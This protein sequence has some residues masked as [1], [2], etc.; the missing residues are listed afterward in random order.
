M[1]M[2]QFHRSKP[3]RKMALGIL[4]TVL[5]FCGFFSNCWHAAEQEWFLHFQHDDE[6]LVIGRMV[7]ARGDGI[8][9]AGGMLGAGI[10]HNIH[11]EWISPEEADHQYT[12][13]LTGL[14]FADYSPYMSQIGGQAMF[15]SLL[16][17]M[18]PLLPRTKINIY[19]IFTSL[20]SAVALTLVVLWFY[21][22]FG[23]SVM[24]FVL[25]SMVFSQWL[26]V[27]GRNLWWSLWVFYLP[28][29]AVMRFYRSHS[30]AEDPRFI[31]L[32]VLTF[33]SV[34]VKC[35]F[36]GYEYMTTTLLMMV[37]PFVYYGIL[38][39]L[40]GRQFLRGAFAAALGSC[41]AIGVT[42]TILCFQIDSIR[43]N[44]QGVTHITNSLMKRTYGNEHAFPAVYAASL[45]SNVID[46]V[47]AYVEGVFFDANNYLSPH[48]HFISRYLFI[49]RY[50]FLI[51]LFLAASLLI[52]FRRAGPAV[53]KQR[54][55]ALLCATWF[56]LL[57]PLSWFVIFKAHSFIHTHMN[58]IVWQM[59]FVFFGFA[60]C[61]MAAK[62]LLSGLLSCPGRGSDGN[63]P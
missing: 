14:T 41:L 59:P 61:G 39:R 17:R 23:L 44:A 27:F 5:L 18:L 6:S 50:Y 30:P 15:F 4:S 1:Q 45:K 21:D 7:K 3:A 33:V 29:I 35:L 46:V 26:T 9:S 54:N 58:F 56:S 40:N 53:V 2:K 28:M 63:G 60:V 10:R 22:E 48:S 16:D 38:Y 57:A 51:V 55:A 8:F 47:D 36:N 62:S 52:V 20:L 49:V 31:R 32:G 34:F 37:T 19:H 43:G 13:Y 12:A 42:L 11:V 25:C 24:L